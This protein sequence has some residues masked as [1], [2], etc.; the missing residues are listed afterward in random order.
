MH[1]ILPGIEFH[2]DPQSERTQVLASSESFYKGK[3]G[4]V[5]KI[6]ERCRNYDVFFNV[7]FMVESKIDN[8]YPKDGPWGAGICVY[9]GTRPI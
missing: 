5:I 9:T 8:T 7:G 4:M 6:L 1:E 3:H 2:G